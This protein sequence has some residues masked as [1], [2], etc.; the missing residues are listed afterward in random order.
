MVLTKPPIPEKPQPR[1]LERATQILSARQPQILPTQRPT[2]PVPAKEVAAASD[3][4]LEAGTA[5]LIPD[6]VPEDKTVETPIA[7]EMPYTT[8]T[9]PIADMAAVTQ[10]K[11]PVE[12]AMPAHSANGAASKLETVES[13]S[14]QRL[15]QSQTLAAYLGWLS[16]GALQDIFLLSYEDA[17]AIIE[18]LKH[19]QILE[20]TTALAPRFLPI[21]PKPEK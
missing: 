14:T 9:H 17:K 7:A 3:Q 15:S 10:E 16:P 12:A 5:N 1:A 6:L 2:R 13:I 11:V 18:E 20:E 21:H 8:E 4:T 19:Q